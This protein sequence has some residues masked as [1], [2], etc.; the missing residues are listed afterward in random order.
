MIIVWITY[1]EYVQGC[2]RKVFVG[3]EYF[4]ERKKKK[5]KCIIDTK[6][7]NA[8]KHWKFQ[9]KNKNRKRKKR[10]MHEFSSIIFLT[11]LTYN[12][13]STWRLNYV[14]LHTTLTIAPIKD[15]KPAKYQ[16]VNEEINV[17][18]HI[19]REEARKSEERGRNRRECKS[20]DGYCENLYFRL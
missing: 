2:M 4:C 16:C 6:K 15:N 14:T 10:E 19:M 8:R 13:S 3:S 18:V 11:F 12:I 17:Y 9:E 1:R 20:V 7:E 5:E